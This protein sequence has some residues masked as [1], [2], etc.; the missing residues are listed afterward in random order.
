MK[1]KAIFCKKHSS[2]GHLC[3]HRWPTFC[4]LRQRLGSNVEL[5]LARVQLSLFKVQL[6][7]GEGGEW[8]VNWAGTNARNLARK[9]ETW[10]F[11]DRKCLHKCAVLFAGARPGGI[12][13]VQTGYKKGTMSSQSMI[14]YLFEQST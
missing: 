11:L 10:L 3:T 1:L 13:I 14:R 9:V 2:Y 4:N 7:T 12:L 6:S 5:L 8:D